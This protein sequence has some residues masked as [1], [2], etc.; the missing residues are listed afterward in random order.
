MD[1][2]QSLITTGRAQRAGIHPLVTVGRGLKDKAIKQ[3]AEALAEI[4]TRMG[5][6]NGEALALRRTLGELESQ[7]QSDPAVTAR[8]AQVEGQLADLTAHEA[9]LF[10][11]LQRL[12][13]DYAQ[14]AVSG[15]VA[16]DVA[17]V[18]KRI[19]AT[20]EKMRE[21]F[22]GAVSP[23]RERMLALRQIA[24]LADARG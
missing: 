3:A 8:L 21:M 2:A 16:N 5:P 6:L 17:P 9:P 14:R 15:L 1:V 20:V 4:S 18:L 11:D 12:V 7:G 24:L 19:T 13:G 23:A 10:A 22:E